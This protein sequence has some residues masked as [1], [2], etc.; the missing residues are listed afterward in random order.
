MIKTVEEVDD[1][2]GG[3]LQAGFPKYSAEGGDF[4]LNAAVGKTDAPSGEG[5]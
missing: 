2:A 5:A 4:P 3:R 1:S